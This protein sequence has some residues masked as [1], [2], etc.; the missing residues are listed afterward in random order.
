MVY[1]GGNFESSIGDVVGKIDEKWLK[2]MGMFLMIVSVICV[3]MIIMD[4][5]K[6]RQSINLSTAINAALYISAFV[7]G[8]YLWKPRMA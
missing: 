3:V 2:A 6:R 8:F 4:I 7:G 1:I 5:M